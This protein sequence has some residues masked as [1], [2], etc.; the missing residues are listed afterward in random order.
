MRNR[1]AGGS[2]ES[3]LFLSGGFLGLLMLASSASRA[4]STIYEAKDDVPC[5]GSER[6]APEAF[7]ESCSGVALD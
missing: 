4:F 5:L 3:L 2:F 7:S 6:R 1:S